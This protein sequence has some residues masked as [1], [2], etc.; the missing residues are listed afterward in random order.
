MKILLV[1]GKFAAEDVMRIAKQFKQHEIDVFVADVDVAAFVTTEHLKNLNLSDY[2]IVILPGNAKGNWRKLEEESGT[3][4]RLGSVHAA[5]LHHVIKNI[6]RVELSHDIPAC[7]LLA[8]IMAEDLINLVNSDSSGV[9]NPAFVGDVVIGEGRMK[10]VAEVVDAPEMD[11][12]NLI[13]R[14][15]YYT[16]NG[17]DV[18]D[19]GIPIECDAEK[20]VKAVKVALDVC[21]AVSVDTFNLSVIKKCVRAGVHMVMSVGRENL[22]ALEY[23]DSQA[24]VIVS[25]DVKDLNALVRLA[26]K[27]GRDNI[28][29]DC[30]LDA[31]LSLYA[32][33]SRYA[34]YRKI[35]D[36]TPL[37][38]GAGNVTELCDADSTG[39]NALLA[40]LAE[41]IGANAMF[42]T[43]AS[44][45]TLGS[46]KELKVAS[47]MAR[48]AKL[49]GSPPKDFGFNLLILKEKV[50]K[51][52]SLK[53]SKLVDA[54]EQKSFVKDPKGNF[55]I[56]VTGNS[57]LAIHESGIA[58]KGNAES[59][60]KTAIKLGLI[61]RLDHA[62]YIGRELMKA[63]IAAKLGKSYVQDEDLNFG[64][65]NY[66]LEWIK[67]KNRCKK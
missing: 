8:S 65:F 63:E 33:L 23:I 6:E 10:I 13:E 22:K 32:S 38:I 17:A 34:E 52:E 54:E 14:I 26:R 37:L 62:A 57:V 19:I 46:I 60:S 25:R 35:D 4:V 48:A 9:K 50:R 40:F 5:D 49:R 44:C 45:K 15:E 61:S 21:D 58:I 67:N 2:D 11:R 12:D 39:M 43:E 27:M 41:E 30:I 31:P 3:K 28:I 18:V 59:I 24:V 20:A 53:F 42:T 36:E 1:T 7:K 47:Y 56:H 55:R 51:R 64:I 66:K 29:A 16:E